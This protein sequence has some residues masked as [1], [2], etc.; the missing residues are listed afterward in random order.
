MNTNKD[1]ISC[2]FCESSGHKNLNPGFRTMRTLTLNAQRSDQMRTKPVS[3]PMMTTPPDLMSRFLSFLLLAL[4]MPVESVLASETDSN[5]KM[6][7]FS[8]SLESKGKVEVWQTVQ[9]QA[10]RIKTS[11]GEFLL[12][13]GRVSGII[14]TDTSGVFQFDLVNGDAVNGSLV[15]GHSEI[16]TPSGKFDLNSPEFRFLGSD[17]SSRSVRGFPLYRMAKVPFDQIDCRTGDFNGDGR[18][19]LVVTRGR[20]NKVDIYLNRKNQALAVS[21]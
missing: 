4:L 21:E 17:G 3:Y 11:I 13:L 14:P 12:P 15:D 16:V 6:P 10:L 9:D 5:D 7:R 20:R 18:V 19:D 1:S 2:Y 8:F